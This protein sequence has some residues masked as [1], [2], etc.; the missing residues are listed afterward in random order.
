MAIMIDASVF[1][2]FA[3]KNDVHHEKANKIIKDIVS[4]KYGAGLTTDYVFDE[5]VTVALRKSNKRN[6]VE[7]G[8]SI[9]NSE[10]LIAKTDAGLFQLA[11]NIF[12]K[13]DGFSFTD[14]SILA[15][16]KTFGITNIA[17]F[18]K[19]FRKIGWLKVV[20]R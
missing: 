8:N 6:A 13:E 3:N 19:E 4:Q 14:C 12:Q 2:A 20:D 1:C 5:T 10:I 15:F 9:I 17:T 7:L 18:D 11:W 16:M